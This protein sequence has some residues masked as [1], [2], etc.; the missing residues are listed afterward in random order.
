MKRK[1]LIG[2]NKTVLI[3]GASSGIGLELA[4]LFAKDGFNLVLVA[5]RKERLEDIAKELNNLYGIKTHIITKDLSNLESPKEIFNELNI[6]SIKI[7]ILVNNAGFD[8]YGKFS[9]T[10]Y[11]KELNM[12]DVNV[13][14]VTYLTKLFLPSMVERNSGK[15]LNIGSTGSIIAAPLNAIYC[16]TKAYVLN[17]S[18]AI[19]EELRGTGITITCLCPGATR[20]EFHKLAM[21]LDTNLMQGKVMSAEKV[22]KIGY[23]AL[24]KGKRV[25]IAGFKNKVQTFMTRFISRKTTSKMSK[26]YLEIKNS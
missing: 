24:M 18:L 7:D 16:A 2:K 3:T 9:E 17:M 14:A 1:E 6:E 19:G 22:A 13:L 25:V 10:N 20:T 15:I 8:V 21:M 5:R 12:I 23:K 4:K 11:E 26:S